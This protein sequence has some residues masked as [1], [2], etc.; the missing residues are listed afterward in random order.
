M[1]FTYK[2]YRDLIH[3]LKN[4]GYSVGNYH[5]YLDYEKVAILRHDVDL[6]IEKALLMAKF[7]Q[8]LGITSTYF[9]LI[10]TDFYNIASQ[11]VQIKIKR[12]Q[13]MGH[14]VGLHFDETKYRN[15]NDTSGILPY[16]QN[17]VK[18]MELLLEIPIHTVSMHRP[19][20]T[21]LEADY[22][23]GDIVNSYSKI[24]FRDFKYISDSRRFWK[25]DVV[26]IINSEN[27]N[28]LH[29]LTHPFWYNENE[30]TIEQSIFGFVNDANTERYKQLQ[31]NICDLGE[32]M[33]VTEVR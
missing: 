32:I 21:T 23:L 30:L 33:A 6:S 28:R 27:F 26:T 7:E 12:I 15:S 25:E 9:F 4:K 13:N 19:S 11:N 10:S 22:D 17:E 24:F 8:S 18:V 2:A 3:L 5:N 16:L 31:N 29:I 20:A 1:E 14:E